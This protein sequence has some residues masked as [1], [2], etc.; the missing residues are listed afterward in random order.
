MIRRLSLNNSL[1]NALP[2]LQIDPALNSSQLLP[3]RSPAL[4]RPLR[5]NSARRTS[6][7]A[8]L[9]CFIDVKPVVYDFALRRPFG[10][11]GGERLPHVHAGRVNFCRRCDNRNCVRENS[12]SVSRFRS[13]PNQRG[14][15]ISRLLTTVMNW[16]FSPY[17][18]RPTPTCFS[19]AF[20]RFAA[21]RSRYRRSIARTVLLPA[22]G[23]V[24]LGGWFYR[25]NDSTIVLCAA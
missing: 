11:A 22:R 16:I 5:K 7:T 10:N 6:L 21:H 14:S 24:G 18:F 13:S 2:A 20:R 25:T 23:K 17:R 3:S 4:P 8:S 12:S 15:P 19:G 9:A 1:S